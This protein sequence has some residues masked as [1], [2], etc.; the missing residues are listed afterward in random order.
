V[1]V[2]RMHPWR[3]VFRFEVDGKTKEDTATYWDLMPPR[4]EPGAPVVVLH[5]PSRSVLW[6]RLERDTG[7]QPVARVR[8]AQPVPQIEEQGADTVEAELESPDADNEQASRS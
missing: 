7:P 3:V 1:R 8:V 5:T 2:N 4:I 6:T